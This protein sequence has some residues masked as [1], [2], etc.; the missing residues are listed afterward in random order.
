MH[1]LISKFSR[2]KE[3]RILSVFNND[4][5]KR[6]YIQQETNA[7]ITKP[8]QVEWNIGSDSDEC[9]NVSRLYLGT[10]PMVSRMEKHI[11]NGWCHIHE[12]IH[13]AIRRI[14][15][16]LIIC[17]V[18]WDYSFSTHYYFEGIVLSEIWIA[19]SQHLVTDVLF[20]FFVWN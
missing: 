14:E 6:I 17:V 5:L 3:S 12:N 20:S 13:L 9:W 16:Y 15:N 7:T 1:F 10:H 19:H 2:K 4:L 18:I 8:I 11:N